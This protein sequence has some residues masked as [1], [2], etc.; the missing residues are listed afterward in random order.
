MKF[1]G[2]VAEYNPFHNGHHYQIQESVKKLQADGVL[3]V[4]SGQFVQR[5]APAFLDKWTRAHS[6][7]AGG[8]NLVL[9]LPTYYAT[10]S[11]EDFAYGALNILNATGI[12]KWLSFGSETTSIDEL[13]WIAR[14][15]VDEPESYRLSL[16]DYLS[17][18]YSFPKARDQAI[19]AYAQ[20]H[21]QILRIDLNQPNTILGIEYLKSLYQMKSSIE[22]FVVKRKGQH[23]HDESTKSSFA[24][25]TAI[26]AHYFKEGHLKKDMDLSPYMPS[27][28]SEILK[29]SLFTPVHHQ[30]M[31]REL[32]YILRRLPQES[33]ATFREVNEGLDYKLKKV[34]NLA[35]SYE[36]LIEMLKSK[37]YP[38]TKITRM[39][40]N[41]YLG[42]KPLKLPLEKHG[43]LRVLAMDQRGKE[44]LKLMKKN[45]ALPIITNINKAKNIDPNNPL[46]EIDQRASD[47]YALLQK[48]KLNKLGALDKRK[49]AIIL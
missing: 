36:D 29:N 26:R 47:L 45:A 49:K 5:G 16:Q 17:S 10:S 20:K 25:A 24:S 14:M 2:I 30:Q 32:L 41:I 39:L 42:I 35:T 48:E 9:E 31:E 43:Y 27:Q 21:G 15:L 22:P 34:C 12:I 6:A 28:C 33:L 44:M 46:M 40:L 19:N 13:H 1:I 4:M 38:L 3:V 18:G 37:R 8:A 7:L 11:A 23:Y